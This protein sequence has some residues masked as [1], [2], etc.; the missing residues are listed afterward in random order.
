MSPKNTDTEP[1]DWIRESLLVYVLSDDKRIS[2]GLK[3]IP[4]MVTVELVSGLAKNAVWLAEHDFPV[5]V[6]DPHDESLARSR[7]LAKRRGVNINVRRGDHTKAARPE[8]AWAGMADLVVTSFFHVATTEQPVLFDGLR[9]LTAPGGLV[10]AEWCHPDQ[11]RNRSALSAL[12]ESSE[13]VDP[14]DLRSAFQRWN[15]LVCR[16][17]VRDVDEGLYNARGVITTQFAAQKP[18]NSR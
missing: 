2:L 7:E 16:R 18:F 14:K 12:V 1:N 8:D 6:F 13:M 15:I 10:L 11:G 4:E 17:M 9:N 3:K 5:T